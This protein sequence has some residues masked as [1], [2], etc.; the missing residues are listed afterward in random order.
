MFKLLWKL[1]K[2]LVFV[3]LLM[4]ISIPVVIAI[5]G[6]QKQPM[7]LIGQTMNYE[8][9]TRLHEIIKSHDPRRMR[10]GEIKR[11][12]TTEDDINLVLQYGLSGYK[13]A[14]AR[15]AVSRDQVLLRLS[16]GLQTIRI[17]RYLNLSLVL[18]QR[19]QDFWV[20][21][22]HIGDLSIPDIVSRPLSKGMHRLLLNIKQYR[23]SIS[24]IKQ[25]TF[26]PNQMVLVYQWRPELVKEIAVAHRKIFVSPEDSERL[27]LYQERIAE[28]SRQLPI[29][30]SATDM[31][32]PLFATAH[33][34]SADAERAAAENG[35]LLS[36]LGIYMAGADLQKLL[37][38]PS[39]HPSERAIRRYLTL[40]GRYDLAQHFILSAF[41]A[42]SAGGGIADGLGLFKE[43]KDSQ[44]GSGFSFADLAA[45]RAGQRLAELATSPATAERVQEVIR[46]A[47]WERLYMPSVDNLPEGIQELEFKARYGDLRSEEYKIVEQEIE[48]RLKMCSAYST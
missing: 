23:D 8:H 33:Q 43:F 5:W 46:S 45:D 26:Q 22:L 11:L 13:N 44:G 29:I 2:L 7:V 42:N 30:T 3:W 25:L 9:V 6:V 15:V 28:I 16:A 21:E 14:G 17:D 32:A 19:G 36:A 1:I 18:A 31:L 47:K 48:R 41:L 27:T 20:E 24:A 37:G 35:A 4:L 34:R 12:V 40:D 39:K 10:A 38:L